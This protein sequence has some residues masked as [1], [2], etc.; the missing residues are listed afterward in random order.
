VLQYEDSLGAIPNNS[1]KYQMSTQNYE[2]ENTIEDWAKISPS[3]QSNQE[4]K[5]I[6]KTLTKKRKQI[7]DYKYTFEYKNRSISNLENTT[8]TPKSGDVSYELLKNPS[9]R[10]SI[11]NDLGLPRVLSTK[12]LKS[13]KEQY[14]EPSEIKQTTHTNISNLT[15]EK[16]T[17]AH[18]ENMYMQSTAF[19]ILNNMQ[20]L[21]TTPYIKAPQT[22]TTS[23]QSTVE[24]IL[25]FSLN[26]TTF[27]NKEG[28]RFN[29]SSTTIFPTKISS[30]ITEYHTKAPLTATSEK[31]LDIT[32]VTSEEN[33]TSLGTTIQVNEHLSTSQ[34]VTESDILEYSS[35]EASLADHRD[36]RQNH[37][38]T[39]F[40]PEKVSNTTTEG[41]MKIPLTITSEES[42]NKVALNSEENN[43]VQG[44]TEQGNKHPSSS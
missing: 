30:L 38:T 13:S 16:T 37:S 17:L 14:T 12:S 11:D 15:F 7:L 33:I 25:N 32:S 6:V 22:K 40:P 3:F 42:K 24:N 2:S 23:K 35:N 4:N 26:D 44:V 34:L 5:T 29:Q 20:N 9:D 28:I 19:T 39:F 27:E 10:M 8:S 43:T 21:N 31:R 18:H 36:I 1:R 41:Y